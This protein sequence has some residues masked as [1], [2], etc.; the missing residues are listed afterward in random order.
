MYDKAALMQGKLVYLERM[1]RDEPL[2][3]PVPLQEQLDAVRDA[4]AFECAYLDAQAAASKIAWGYA[5]AQQRKLRAGVLSLRTLFEAE[6]G[7]AVQQHVDDG[8]EIGL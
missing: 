7:P 2:A 5:K 1:G 6:R 3:V 4:A 8:S